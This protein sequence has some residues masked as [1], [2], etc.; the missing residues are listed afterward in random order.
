MR[1]SVTELE[2]K[3]DKH[4]FDPLPGVDSLKKTLRKLTPFD[5]TKRSCRDLVPDLLYDIILRSNGI[6]LNPAETPCLKS[7]GVDEGHFELDDTVDH[8]LR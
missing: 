1:H 2:V 3:I 4:Y 6:G 5:G 7:R 8:G